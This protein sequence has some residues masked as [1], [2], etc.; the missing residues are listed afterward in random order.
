M[1]EE[2]RYTRITLRMPRELHRR[3]SAQAERKSHSLNAEIVAMLE[4]G[5][6]MVQP[7]LEQSDE[8]LRWLIKVNTA[9]GEYQGHMSRQIH[10]EW[11]AEKY[12]QDIEMLQAQ[13]EDS[14]VAGNANVIPVIE[15]RLNELRQRLEEE[16]KLLVAEKEMAHFSKGVLAELQKNKPKSQP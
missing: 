10:Y 16:T 15:R 11:N 6:Q 8:E 13:L 3:L 4:Y 5:M 9:N 14:R 1:D 12:R 7:R 2:D